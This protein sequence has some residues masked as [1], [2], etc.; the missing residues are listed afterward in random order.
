VADDGGAD[1]A[2]YYVWSAGREPRPLL[3]AACRELG[4]GRGCQAIDLGC[5][6]GTDA[7]E[8]LA[9]GWSV[10]AIDAEPAGLALLRARI[11]SAAAGRI[12]V[13]CASFAEA[14]L[15]CAHLIHAGFSLPF[16]PPREFPALWARIRRALAPGGVFAG[17]L[18]GTHDTWADDPDMTFHARHQADT[19]LA[20]LDILHLEETEQD[21]HAFSGPKHWHT[22]D[23]LARRPVSKHP[24]GTGVP[25]AAPLR[26]DGRSVRGHVS[27][28][29]ASM[30]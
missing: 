3:R 11:P 21:G 4:A 16:C 14:D 19:L 30:S 15:P 12:R 25:L 27:E 28:S 9:R 10:L 18:F 17:Q 7:L 5:G 29:G 1:W 26:C 24:I 6:E 8:L 23:I 20:G 2:G 13:V 22:F